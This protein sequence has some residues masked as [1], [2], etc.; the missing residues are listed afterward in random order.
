MNFFIAQHVTATTVM[1][2]KSRLHYR[3]FKAQKLLEISEVFWSFT[4]ISKS[5]LCTQSGLT[6]SEG[7]NIKL[8]CYRKSQKSNSGTSNVFNKKRKTLTGDTDDQKFNCDNADGHSQAG[9]RGKKLSPSWI[10]K[11]S[12]K[13]KSNEKRLETLFTHRR[14]NIYLHK[15]PFIVDL[16]DIKS[17]IVFKFS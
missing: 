10:R 2:F 3:S 16:T 15:L 17:W 9:N 11:T 7:R 6:K 5:I 1:K 8:R 13:K 4:C 14:S 12:R